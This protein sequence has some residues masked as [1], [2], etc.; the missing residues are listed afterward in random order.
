MPLLV[1]YEAGRVIADSKRICI[2]LDAVS[3]DPVQLVPDAPAARVEVMR[4]VSI[5]DRIPNGALLYGFHPDAYLRPEALKVSMQT[6]YD[7]K[8]MVLERL[9]ADNAGEPDLV[10]AYRAKIVK[11]SGGKEVCR[12][13]EFQRAARQQAGQLLIDLE[14]DLAAGSFACTNGHAFSLADVLWGVNLVR[15]NY[16]GLASMWDPLPRVTRCFNVLARRPSCATKRSR[17]RLI[18][19]RTPATWMPWRTAAPKP[20]PDASRGVAKHH[21]PAAHCA[22]RHRSSRPSLREG[23]RVRPMTFPVHGD[24]P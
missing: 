24:I 6:V 4:Q 1:D 10:A 12:D 20:P 19:C 14:R 15:L 2:Y 16:L 18:R 11:E 9:M 13:P 3:R 22:F 8:V 21:A 23:G 7:Y 17:R 5:V